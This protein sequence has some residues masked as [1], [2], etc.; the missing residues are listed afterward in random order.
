ML[1]AI[2]LL[3]VGAVVA[4][5]VWVRVAPDDPARWNTGSDAEGMGHVS[6]DNW[7]V[8]REAVQGDGKARLAELDAALRALDRTDV[9]AGSPDAGR[10][11][12]VTRSA[13][14]GFPDYTTLSLADGPDGPVIE[15]FA[16]ARYGTSDF[17]V[18]GKRIKALPGIPE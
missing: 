3:V 18:N 7:H 13:L 17:G 4:G 12:Y 1:K 14:I 2:G 9:L 8:W 6:G 5:A 10:I 11:T 15:V 16:R